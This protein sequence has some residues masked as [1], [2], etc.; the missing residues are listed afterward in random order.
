MSAG[1]FTPNLRVAFVEGQVS[2]TPDPG[3]VA[4]GD[5]LPYPLEITGADINEK[6]DR[7]AEIIYRVK[8][9]W[10]IGGE[11]TFTISGTPATYSGP[12]SAPANRYTYT[13]ATEY[14][15]RGYTVGGVDIGDN[16][17]DLWG[18]DYGPYTAFRYDMLDEFGINAGDAAWFNP[19]SRSEVKLTGNVAIVRADPADGFF[20]STNR[21]FL[22]LEF[23]FYD[24]GVPGYG[25]TT[26][27]TASG[28]FGDAPLFQ[29]ACNYEMQLSNCS[30]TCPLYFAPLDD[31]GGSNFIHAAQEWWPYAKN[32]PSEPV[33]N[34]A[35]GAK[36]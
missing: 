6:L 18:N 13:S 9:A 16:E 10:F 1:V 20:A 21:F 8:D 15:I 29:Q 4:C 27:I 2:A 3:F 30:L 7:L 33:W 23:Y 25:A 36:L 5:G 28:I 24:F 32:S 22:Q 35:T 34:S 26:D 31:L 12:T 14:Q 17:R 19:G 11:I